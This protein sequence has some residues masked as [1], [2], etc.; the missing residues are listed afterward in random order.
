MTRIKAEGLEIVES[1]GRYASSRHEGPTVMVRNDLNQAAGAFTRRASTLF[2]CLGTMAGPRFSRPTP[3]PVF[4]CTT[5]IGST[6]L[7][8]P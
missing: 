7:G 2:R 8:R 5:T 6:S 3:R 1:V 4:G